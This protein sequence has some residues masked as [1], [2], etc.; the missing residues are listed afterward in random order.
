MTTSTKPYAVRRISPTEQHLVAGRNLLA[1]E[2]ILC[3]QSILHIEI[4]HYEYGT[5]VWDMVDRLLADK[6]L[7]HQYVRCQLLATPLFTDEQDKAVE[8]LLITKHRKSRQFIR[9]LYYGV[10]TNNI[11]I[12]DHDR[13]VR[14]YGV[15]PVLSR[16]DHSCAP[17]T[18]LTPANW[19]AAESSL[20]AS[21]DIRAG[22]PLTWSYFREAE[23]LPQDWV[24]RNYN[25]VNLYRFACRCPRCAAERP[26]D[27]PSSSA[28]QVAYIDK[29][30]KVDAKKLASSPEGLE[31]LLAECPAN[32]HR[33][34]LLASRNR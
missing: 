5:Y 22:E 28:G 1:G 16:S 26:V 10:G 13:L 25:L 33:N 7:L 14:G 6:A 27:V 17:N 29:L 4:G 31:K 34:Q 18:A 19:R 11:G 20:S 3:E 21:R 8:D 2:V 30:L 24:T 23:F 15:Y 12:L 9:N 32:M